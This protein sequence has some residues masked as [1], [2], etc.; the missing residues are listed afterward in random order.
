M[1]LNNAIA[2]SSLIAVKK[3]AGCSIIARVIYSRGNSHDQS[4]NEEF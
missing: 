3:M 4:G 1:I 2:K